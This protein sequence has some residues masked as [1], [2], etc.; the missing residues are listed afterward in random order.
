MNSVASD[1]DV[2]ILGA[3]A[4][5]M[6]C[7]LEAGKRGRSVA[8]LD[9]G[10]Q[11]GSKIL[12]SGGG[13]CNFTNLGVSAKNYVSQN[14]HCCKSALS[15]YGCGEILALVKE[16]GLPYEERKWGQLFFK[17][18]AREFVEYLR[19]QCKEAGVQ[20]FLQTAIMA[21]V[22]KPE[23]AFKVQTS[24]GTFSGG[25]LVVATGGLSIPR[26]GATGFGYE[27]A[28]QFGH[29]VI[30][31]APALDGFVFSEADVGRFGGFAGLSLDAQ[32]SCGVVSFR[33]ALLFTHTGLS[34]P[35]SLQ[36]S[37]HWN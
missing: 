6:M 8:L 32:I 29:T 1:F 23:G 10:V 11:V 36:A 12:I 37:L 14:P 18:S 27:I 3:G 31:A 21:I 20:I 22:R 7:A 13:R 24:T 28:R 34:G 4:S 17:C 2:I 15:R 5:G 25:S 16:S 33:E 19:S 30:T 35:V 9:H 26:T